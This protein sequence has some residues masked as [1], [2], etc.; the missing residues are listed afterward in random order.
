MSASRHTQSQGK[1]NTTGEPYTFPCASILKP[2][3]SWI[4]GRQYEELSESAIRYSSNTA[5]NLLVERIERQQ[6]LT[7]AIHAATA[8]RLP[9]GPTWG[10]LPVTVSEVAD[11]YEAFLNS[12]KVQQDEW[13]ATLYSYMTRTSTE[14]RLQLDT[15]ANVVSEDSGKNPPAIKIGWDKKR[16]NYLYTHAVQIVEGDIGVVL[17]ATPVDT[18]CGEEWE[19]ALEKNGPSAVLPIHEHHVGKEL[20]D[21]MAKVFA[22]GETGDRK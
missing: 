7:D 3:I 2:I 19:E 21:E 17:T 18:A 14:Q 11:I 1:P 12:A 13:T 8:V 4:A 10:T 6:R 9:N 20:R 16:D 5:T 22:S 15:T